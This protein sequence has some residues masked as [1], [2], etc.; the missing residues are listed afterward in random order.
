M[1]LTVKRSKNLRRLIVVLSILIP[2]VVAVLFKVQI[3]GVDLTFLP[4]IYAG[5]NALTAV[6]LVAALVLVKKRKLKQHENVIKICMA[7]SVLFL[8]CYV[9]YHMTSESTMY[10]DTS[11]DHILQEVELLVVSSASRL[12][13][14][15]LLISHILLSVAVVPLVLYSFL[16]ATEGRFEKHRKLTKITWPIWFYV[17]VSGVIVYCMI[18]PYYQ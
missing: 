12:F 18:S 7:L 4:P 10:G 14:F 16:F 13:Y 1:E 5:I 3:K 9:A 15:I 8:L 17:A 6:L 11:G 2:V